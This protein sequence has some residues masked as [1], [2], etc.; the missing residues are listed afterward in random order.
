M[1]DIVYWVTGLLVAAFVVVIALLYWRYTRWENSVKL[2]LEE[3][4]YELTAYDDEL[5]VILHQEGY[6]PEAAARVIIYIARN[7]FIDY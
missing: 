3:Y 2:C 6:S 4:R 1:S 5:L 7:T